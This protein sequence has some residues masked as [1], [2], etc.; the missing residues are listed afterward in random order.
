MGPLA[1]VSLGRVDTF[2]PVLQTVMCV[3]DLITATRLFG[4]YSIRPKSSILV[5]ASAAWSPARRI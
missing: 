3:V 2:I 5:V 1:T 4:Q